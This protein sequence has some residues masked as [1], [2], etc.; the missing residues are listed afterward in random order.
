[1]T[2]AEREKTWFMFWER[3][4]RAK[5]RLFCFPYAGGGAMIYRTWQASLPPEIEVC[6]VQL[7]GRETRIREDPRQRL[8][9]LVFELSLVIEPYL[10][11][12]YALFGHS[13]GALIAFELARELRRRK[14]PQPVHLFVS[15]RP[16]P[17]I[18]DTRPPL[19]TL[20]DDAFIEKLRALSGTPEAVLQNEELMALMLPL[21]RA[22]FAK[23]E[24]YRYEAQ[25]PLDTPITAFGGLQDERVPLADIDAWRVQTT[26]A[27]QKRML[28]GG[29]FFLN[30]ERALLLE[31]I[32]IDL[33]SCLS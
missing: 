17:Q 26:K 19:H 11:M 27:F 7:P 6:P 14:A 30:T 16:A 29:H 15:G 4:P 28:P 3:N 1:M 25:P 10:D 23:C 13:M 32:V 24:T 9:P 5:V 12:P 20:D 33:E 31:G 18:P 8:L 2:G 21:L 22:D